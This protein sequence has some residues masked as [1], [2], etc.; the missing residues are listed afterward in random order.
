MRTREAGDD[1]VN[2][3]AESFKSDLV[4]T[5][6]RELRAPLPPIVDL[7]TL[8]MK[9][10]VSEDSRRKFLAIIIEEGTRLMELIDKFSTLSLLESGKHE[11]H[12]EEVDIR[13]I[14]DRV[15]EVEARH[16]PR[17]QLS[18]EIPEDLPVVKADPERISTAIQVLVSNAVLYSP[19]GGPVAITGQEEDGFVAISVRDHGVGIRNQDLPM[20]FRR[21]QRLNREAAPNARGFGLGLSICKGIVE[22]HGGRVRVDSVYGEGSTFTLLLPVRGPA[23]NRQVPLDI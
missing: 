2:D 14:V 3:K 23:E 15:A 9:N 13:T 12:L 7:A 17:H 10:D 22:Q 5:V 18:N 6:A 20:L 19:A 21:F 1:A 11:L 4:A 8:M 16:Q